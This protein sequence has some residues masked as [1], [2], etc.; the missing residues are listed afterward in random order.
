MVRLPVQRNTRHPRP[1]GM[2]TEGFPTL[3]WATTSWNNGAAVPTLL[4]VS[5]GFHPC[6]TCPLSCC[7][8][9]G[10]PACLAG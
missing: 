9:T 4:F 3:F 1:V 6:L 5:A 7:C 2:S 8:T 10:F